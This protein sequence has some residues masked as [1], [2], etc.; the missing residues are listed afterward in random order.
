MPATVHRDLAH[1][2]VADLALADVLFALSDPM[3]LAIVRQLACGPLVELPCQE[4]GGPAP[5]ST[6]SHHLKTLREAGVIR[7][8]PHGRE[9]RVSLRRAELDSRFPGLLD[10]VLSAAP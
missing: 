7:N 4:V 2:D 1:P 9:R 8:V 3:R 10:A 6:R 5:K